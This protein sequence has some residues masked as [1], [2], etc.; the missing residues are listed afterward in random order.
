M[1]TVPAWPQNKK[2]QKW[3]NEY[4]IVGAKNLDHHLRLQI[5]VIFHGLLFAEVHCLKQILESCY[6]N[7]VLWILANFSER[8]KEMS[9][10]KDNEEGCG[11]HSTTSIFAQPHRENY[12]QVDNYKIR[13][14]GSFVFLWSSTV[15]QQ[16]N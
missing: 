16:L 2:A 14:H 4:F 8:A 7:S 10:S 11:M 5:P 3:G 1:Q 6:G 13:I 15:Q 12:T 9:K